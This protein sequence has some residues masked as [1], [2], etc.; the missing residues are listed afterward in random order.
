MAEYI[1]INNIRELLKEDSIESLDVFN[2]IKFLS[3]M[4][5]NPEYD[6]VQ[7]EIQ[8]LVLR[9]L[10][11]R[12]KLDI[13]EVLLDALVRQVG[14]FP[15]VN[16]NN[17]SLSDLIAYEYHR[18]SGLENIVFHRV[19][20]EIYLELLSGENIILSAPTSFGK[21][22][23]IDAIIVAEKFNN[24]LILVPTI[25]L[26]DETRR[27]LSKYKQYYKIIT[28]QN[29]KNGSRNIFI[30]TQERAMELIENINI[31]LVIID[32]FYKIQPTDE[33]DDRCI[34]LNQAFYKLLKSHPQFYLLGP[35]IEQ[36]KGITPKNID[37]KFIK[38]DYRTVVTEYHKID[39]GDSRLQTL[40]DLAESLTE[41]TLIYCRSP[42]SANLVA[43][44]MIKSGK[45]CNL[46]DLN[47]ATQWMKDN[48][49]NSWL[50]AKALEKGIGIHHG[51]IPRAVSQFCIRA[52]NNGTIRYLICTSTIIEG[53]NTSAKNV[54][55]FDN[56]V[57]LK[58]IDYFTF[59]NISGR[60][61]RMFKHF[62]GN[63]YLF[64]SPPE[65]NLPTVDFP[66]F[67]QEEDIS[68]RLLIQMDDQ[69]L[70][71]ISRDKLKRYKMQNV[72]S[73]ETLKSNSTAEPNDQIELAKEILSNLSYYHPFLYWAG[74][75][76]YEQLKT[77]C[78]LIWTY[79]VK[80]KRTQAG[81]NSGSQLAYK[82][83]KLIYVEDVKELID[84]DTEGQIDTDVINKNIDGV[85]D[86]IRTWAMYKFPTL[87]LVLDNIQKDVFVKNK[88]KPGDY[89]TFASQIENLFLDPTL[90][91]LDEYGIPI[92]V[93][94]KIIY[95]LKPEGNLDDVLQRLGEI[96]IDDLPLTNFE[97]YLVRDT[98]S[99][100]I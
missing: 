45:F 24:I 28:H 36:I 96:N 78:E 10:D 16:E 27:R 98:K 49:H 90:I 71:E 60:S 9:L 17:L 73:I 82:I 25:A 67:S 58:Q 79:L 64:H 75:P 3:I 84:E 85:L 41:P 44:A 34:V 14:L 68:E 92:Q 91:A 52:F 81:I 11:K 1:N 72:L 4:V 30:L 23:I 37:F 74:I 26:I 100:I 12:D 6:N 63:V 21:S 35:N 51:K 5:N 97:K 99:Y 76:N 88:I 53:V 38:T 20:A 56:Q 39:A 47:E 77:V 46:D 83:N 54:I 29:Q 22:L 8:E 19:Q 61:G 7:G 13:Y 48:Y 2:T 89:T 94:K 32:E 95:W 62:I 15:Y 87:L 33:Y 66:L 69:D 42:N 65:S 59:N 93:S 43:T 86:F 40:V 70:N 31:D 50:L 18:P 57:A 80:P 55:I